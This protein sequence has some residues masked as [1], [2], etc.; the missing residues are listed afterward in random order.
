VN[1]EGR[2]G[3]QRSQGDTEVA[4]DTQAE[5]QMG[6]WAGGRVGRGIYVQKI[7]WMCQDLQI[8][9]V[10]ALPHPVVP[11]L[12]SLCLPSTSTV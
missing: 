2:S 1:W 6:G 5:R 7:E 12:C 9:L 10:T 8:S 4:V 3:L 11:P